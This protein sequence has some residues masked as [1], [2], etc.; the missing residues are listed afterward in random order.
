[1]GSMLKNALK[2]VFAKEEIERVYSSFDIIGDI[3]IIK[4]PEELEEKKE[5]I[6]KTLINK[7]KTVKTVFQQISSV[8]GEYRTRRL[9]FLTGINK[10]STEYREHGCIFKVDVLKTYFSPRLAT[11]RLRVS[12]LIGNNEIIINM[13]AG[14]GTYS[15]ILAKKNPD[16]IV[17]SIDSNPYANDLCIINSKLNKV[18]DRVIPILGNARTI[19]SNQLKGKATRVLM[20][21]PEQASEFIDSAIAALQNNKGVIHYFAHIKSKSKLDALEEGKV[22][23]HNHFQ[24]YQYKI[25]SGKVVREVGPRIYQTVFDLEIF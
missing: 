12:K 9:C 10:S 25:I 21:L 20:P 18:Q 15:I 1:M 19:I 17:Y 8:Q 16:C 11:E 5:I 6:A 13:F 3:I 4:I 24:C 14:I 23:C 2:D 22:N 7:I